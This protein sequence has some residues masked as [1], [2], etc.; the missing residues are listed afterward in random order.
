MALSAPLLTVWAVSDGRA[1]MANQALGLAEAVARL[2]PAEISVK[3]VR[4]RFGAARLPTALMLAPRALLAE[5]LGAPPW[6]DLWI[7]VGR[8][9][10]P[11]SER[12]RRWSGGRTFVVQLQRPRRPPNRFDLVVPPVHDGLTGGNVFP[13]LGSPH[14]VTPERLTG[15]GQ[16]YADLPSPIVA[17]LV[18]G[19]SK[20]FDLPPER[21]AVLAEDIAS[22]VEAVRGS[23]LV[24][25]SRRTPEAAQAVM[26]AQ[27]ARL[28]GVVWDGQGA[29]PYFDF[30]AAADAVLVT[31]DST[32]MA[33][34][35][36]ATGK[37]VHVLRTVGGSAK[38]S[39]LHAALQAHGATRPFAGRIEKWSYPPLRET[40]RAAAEVVEALSRRAA[41]RAV[42]PGGPPPGR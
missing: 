15:L 33:V 30:L 20:A 29:N 23:V 7:A 12:V 31:E 26:T 3:T 37:P 28:P 18:G 2:S 4:Y 5:P 6:P 19:K 32:N 36:A 9:T 11:L 40:E 16:A 8:A 1:G 27:L 34:E 42:R 10:L 13:I 39:A 24:T 17:V 35:A 14:R 25:F 21:A 38:F 41:E 22:A